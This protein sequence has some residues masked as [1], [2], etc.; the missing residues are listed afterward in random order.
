MTTLI[1]KIRFISYRLGPLLPKIS[2]DYKIN[3]WKTLIQPLINFSLPL[4]AHNT[5][6]RINKFERSLK[7]CFK[8]FLGLCLSTDNKIVNRL[9][10]FNLHE[11]ALSQ[12]EASLSKW[13]QRLFHLTVTKKLK[14]EPISPCPLLPKS[15]IKFVNIQKSKC[16]NCGTLNS[17]HHLQNV[18]GLT[19]PSSL[20]LIDEL[21][22]D[23]PRTKSFSRNTILSGK[24]KRINQYLSIIL[25]HLRQTF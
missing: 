2:T 11:L 9:I 1:S 12:E 22:K 15:F 13:N 6:T 16:P 24:E 4:M 14:S 21:D 18:H 10:H 17:A 23:F 5:W 19:V 7:C 8:R 3:L 20:E 25:N